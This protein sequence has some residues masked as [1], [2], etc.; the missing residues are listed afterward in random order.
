MRRPPGSR[1]DFVL[2]RKVIEKSQT[3]PQGERKHYQT[4]HSSMTVSTALAME[5]NLPYRPCI[6]TLLTKHDE[7]WLGQSEHIVISQL[8]FFQSS[9]MLL[10][11]CASVPW[12]FSFCFNAT[13]QTLIQS[14]SILYEHVWCLSKDPENKQNKTIIVPQNS[15]LDSKGDHVITLTWRHRVML[16]P[17]RDLRGH[18]KTNDHFLWLQIWGGVKGHSQ[19][20]PTCEQWPAADAQP[21]T[22]LNSV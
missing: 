15:P 21:G 1:G 19:Q 12:K 2:L 11:F 18:G 22:Q 8:S 10:K 14:K 3:H 17:L 20:L 9:E 4:C 7:G 5:V 13:I 16:P 6:G